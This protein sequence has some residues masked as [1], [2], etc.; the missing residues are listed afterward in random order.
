MNVIQFLEEFKKALEKV[1][2]EAFLV[3]PR[4]TSERCQNAIKNLKFQMKIFIFF[5]VHFV[6]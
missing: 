6:K 4:R 1:G 5:I 2:I 3:N